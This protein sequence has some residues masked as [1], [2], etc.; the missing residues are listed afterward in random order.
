MSMGA[1][2]RIM[3]LGSMAVALTLSGC[4]SLGGGKAPPTLFT[5]S[6]AS[7][8]VAG[9]TLAGKVSEALVV[10][11]PEADRRLAVTR[12]PVQIDDANVAYLKDAMWVERPTRL[13]RGLLAETLRAKG[14]RLVFEDDQAEARGSLRLSGRLVEM[15]FDARSMSAIVRFDAVRDVGAGQVATRRFEA[16]EPGISADAASVGPALNR[17]AN[18]VAAE[19]AEWSA[20]P[21]PAPR[22][23]PP[24]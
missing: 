9:N 23:A 6:A 3:A 19:V 4:V 13:F 21:A 18:K 8:P 16:I 10:V 20:N 15:G 11:E 17:A 24:R 22:T 14:N 12:V 5:L 1:S 2:M 7:K